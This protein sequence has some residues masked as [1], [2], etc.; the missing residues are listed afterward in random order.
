MQPNEYRPHYQLQPGW[1][2]CKTHC[3]YRRGVQHDADRS[4]ERLRGKGVGEAGTDDARV[5]VRPGD[6]APDDTVLGATDLLVS[7]V[8]VGDALAEVEVGS[9]SV[10][11]TLDL[12]Q[13]D[14]GLGGVT[15]ALVAQ[16]ASLDVEAVA[17]FGRHLVGIMALDPG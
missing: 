5:A 12:D 4:T 13:A 11:N 9:L 17:G 14:G 16:V 15:R 1:G 7:L 8:D 6:L 3:L 2:F 10:V